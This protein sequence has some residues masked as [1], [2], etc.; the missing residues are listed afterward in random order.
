MNINTDGIESEKGKELAQFA[1][2]CL[3]IFSE[4]IEAEIV[5]T[6]EAYAFTVSIAD[7]HPTI[8][9]LESNGD[10]YLMMLEIVNNPLHHHTISKSVIFGTF[11][12][13]WAAPV[14]AKDIADDIAPSEHPE[15][16]RTRLINLLTY[17]GDNAAAM[18]L[19]GRKAKDAMEGY[20]AIVSYNEAQGSLLDAMRECVS[21]AMTTHRNSQN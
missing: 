12:Q 11:S 13:G 21:A 17:D 10:I 15:R 3:E 18:T 1:A 14:T 9:P 19:R 4:G 6:K 8:N 20:D 5:N 7:G 2:L 16:M